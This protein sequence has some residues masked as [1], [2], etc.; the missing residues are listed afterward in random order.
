MARSGWQ[1]EA[2]MRPA[3][4]ASGVE[5]GAWRTPEKERI[6]DRLVALRR[7]SQ[8]VRG[9]CV[10]RWLASGGRRASTTV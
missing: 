3:C 8:T 6:G 4:L 2:H 7:I 9:E 1:R 10:A 5:T